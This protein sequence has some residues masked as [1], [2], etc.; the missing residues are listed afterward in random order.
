MA[1]EQIIIEVVVDNSAA[2]KALT[3][4]TKAVDGLNQSNKQLR[5]TN[6][7]LSQDYKANSVA[8]NKNNEEIAKNNV[9]L[10]KYKQGQK[11]AAQQLKATNNS[12]NA[13]K[14]ALA[15]N[16]RAIGDVNTATKQG[17]KEY[18][19]LEK[20]ISKQTKSLKNAEQAQGTFTRSV[21]DYGSALGQ[22]NP[23]MGSAVSG[24]QAMTK[25]ALAFIATPIG[26][27]IAALG[28]AVGALTEYFQGSEEGQND[29][30]KIT[31]TLSAAWQVFSDLIQ[32]VGKSIFDGITDI[33]GT[34]SSLGQVLQ[35]Q[36]INR[37]NAFGL[38]GKAIVKILK[39]DFK[40]GFTELGEASLQY[41][42]GVEDVIGKT[43]ELANE[44]VAVYDET[45]TR[46][47]ENVKSAGRISQLQAQLAKE[48][49]ETLVENAKLDVEIAN[50]RLAAK[51]EE[52]KTAE[53]RIQLL[54]EA[55][56]LE[57][58]IF[59]N[60]LS[61]AEKKLEVQ[62]RENALGK[63]TKEDKLAEATLEAE[64]IRLNQ[65]RANAQRKLETEI[66]TNIKKRDAERQK[67]ANNELARL[68][69]EEEEKKRIAE[70]EAAESERLAQEQAEREAE[71][72]EKANELAVAKSEAAIGLAGQ[73][74][75]A[76]GQFA[77]E[78]SAVAKAAA[79]GTSTIN[80][81][82]AIT[83]ALA[84][85]P[86]PFNIAAAGVTGALGFAQVANIAGIFEEGGITKFADGGLADGGMFEGASHANGGVKFAVGGKIHEAEGG[87]AIINKRSTAMF[88]PLLS[89][90][91][92]AGGGKKFASG[93]IPLAASST[94][95]ID[96]AMASENSIS[97]QLANQVPAQVAV[98]D[99]NRTQSNV[100][101]KQSRASI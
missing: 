37:I 33:E 23:A 12:L 62:Q 77:E 93:G 59:A 81:Y 42:T 61:I 56:D 47:E 73:T 1:E 49:R 67:E 64:L 99:I 14:A 92:A 44:V 28:L 63:S 57:N 69:A 13:Q 26:A 5:A 68:R 76:V 25:G 95:G 82:Q 29:L 18:K 71:E 86:A 78:G 24:F 15:A 21:G 83:N 19:R 88:K 39:G 4:N 96:S 2:Q 16:K 74:A 87:E 90:L 100:S 84:N 54:K 53:E 101:V 94:A 91:N 40:E 31:N 43:K 41:V 65:T 6:K 27:V 11:A 30:L 50:R 10:T 89:S 7:E 38:A 58:Q 60:Q 97:S 45:Q 66:Q 75:A 3:Q 85:I 55:Q 20:E 48:E 79:I 32:S 72:T 80:T 22:V 52:T 17:Q 70:E 51:D 98:T 9:Q 8:I 35:D 34:F 36:V 46:I